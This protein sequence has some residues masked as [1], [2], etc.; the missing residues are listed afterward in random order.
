M[1]AM[2][3]KSGLAALA[4]ALAGCATVPPVQL[5]E[6]R[7]VFPLGGRYH[8]SPG[9]TPEVV[10]P[11]A[12]DVKRVETESPLCFTPLR[13][14]LALPIVDAHLLTALFRLSHALG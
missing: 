14:A 4:F 3:R 5:V 2:V 6:A 8:P 11:F 1:N 13:E 12:V 7:R 10:Y 9:V